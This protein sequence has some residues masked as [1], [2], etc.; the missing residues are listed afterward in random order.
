MRASNARSH[1][2]ARNIAGALVALLL[3]GAMFLVLVKL[4]VPERPPS[5][6]IF[7]LLVLPEPE[8]RQALIPPPPIAPEQADV[9]NLPEL[10]ELPTAPVISVPPA[11]AIDPPRSAAPPDL[12]GLG[13]VLFGCTLENLGS[14]TA[15]ARA[16][17]VHAGLGGP[18]DEASL[19][20]VAQLSAIENARFE[21]ALVRKQQPLLLPCAGGIGIS[22]Y[23]V[24]CVA[25]GLINGFDLDSKKY[26]VYEPWPDEN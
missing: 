4:A 8:R 7:T 19:A 12:T 5:D 25:D 10:P 17:C 14:L 2:L 26:A 13:R 16:R 22:L 6:P 21:R 9:P 15:E 18:P 1:V 3:H 11:F 20:A 24:L 23:T